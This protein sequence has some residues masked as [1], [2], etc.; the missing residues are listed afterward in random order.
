MAQA[1]I[2]QGRV[3]VDLDRLLFDGSPV[4]LLPVISFTP[5]IWF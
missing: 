1:L 2:C 4:R 3:S 5:K